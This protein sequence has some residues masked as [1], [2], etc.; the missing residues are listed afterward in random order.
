MLLEVRVLFPQG[1]ES[2][3]RI[4]AV[5]FQRCRVGVIVARLFRCTR[6][7]ELGVTKFFEQFGLANRFRFAGEPSLKLGHALRD[8]R[9]HGRNENC[10]AAY[11]SQGRP[12]GPHA[13]TFSVPAC[14]AAPCSALWPA[15]SDRNSYPDRDREI[16]GK[17]QRR[18]SAGSA[19][20]NKSRGQTRRPPPVVPL[21][22]SH[23]ACSAPPDN[24]LPERT[25]S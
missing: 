19:Y 14:V 6:N 18:A 15:R 23:R 13:V 17:H 7:L 3:A 9:R 5:F 11:C 2:S 10:Q 12:A 1:V 16:S 22:Q 24:S 20:R 21:L 4:V 8:A 25:W